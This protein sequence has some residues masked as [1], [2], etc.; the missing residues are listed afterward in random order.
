MKKQ[1]EKIELRSNCCT[2]S[3]ND[4]ETIPSSGVQ[5]CPPPANGLAEAAGSPCHVPESKKGQSGDRQARERRVDIEFMYLDTSV[6]TRCQGTE[7]SLEEA[8]TEVA[9]VLET[10]GIAVTVRK[11]HVR[12]EEQA[13][14]LGFISSPTIRINGRDI[15]PEVKETLCESCGD[16]C[17][18]DVDC[19]VWVYQG[20]EYTAPPKAMIIDAILRE[21]Y[22]GAKAN[23][24][25]PSKGGAL[26][27]NLKL[28]FAARQKNPNQDSWPVNSMQ[29]GQMTSFRGITRVSDR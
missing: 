6:C 12:S 14:E 4:I 10:A 8:V 23:Q 22:G 15:Q 24:P 9:R 27:D 11:T 19:R 29:E 20:K 26:P 3:G 28:F 18:E 25:E 17:G 16:L 5:C 13:K 7:A 1:N 21:V 2:C